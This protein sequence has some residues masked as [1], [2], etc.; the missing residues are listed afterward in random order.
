M[1][2]ATAMLVR[3]TSRRA[4]W[5]VV[6][7]VGVARPIVAVLGAGTDYAIFLIGRYQEG[8]RR[9]VGRTESPRDAYR[10][11]ARVIVA[12]REAAA[13]AAR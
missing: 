4:I 8:R 13:A 10:G 9:A 12:A 5:V 1:H 7:W 2:D 3:F 6:A 11:V